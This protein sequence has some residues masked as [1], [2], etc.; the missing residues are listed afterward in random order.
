MAGLPFSL[1]ISSRGIMA[2]RAILTVANFGRTLLMNG[3]TGRKE[4]RMVSMNNGG[5]MKTLAFALSL[6]MAAGCIPCSWADD[7]D[8]WFRN[9]FDRRRGD[10]GEVSHGITQENAGLTNASA[11]RIPVRAPLR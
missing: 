8:P 1:L 10:Q 5:G 11:H 3:A 9:V 2:E 7:V 6:A 4:S